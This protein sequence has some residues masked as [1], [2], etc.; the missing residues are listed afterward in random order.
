[1]NTTNNTASNT[2]SKT[3]SKTK[4]YIT[5]LDNVNAHIECED[6]GFVMCL[7]ERSLALQRA[8]SSI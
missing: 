1:M 3:A 2:V 5:K 4:A 6:G 7:Y 8:I